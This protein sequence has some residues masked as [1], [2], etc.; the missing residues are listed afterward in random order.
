MNAGQICI[1]PDHVFA[2]TSI[3]EELID[4]LIQQSKEI[5]TDSNYVEQAWP[6]IISEKHFKRVASLIEP[7][8]VVH[9][10]QVDPETHKIDF[11]ILDQPPASSMV[12]QEEIFGPILPILEYN[13]LDVL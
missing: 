11:T 7:D 2:H 4:E 13:N 6:K 1:A 9:G 5:F 8:Y 12:M 3:K 10:G